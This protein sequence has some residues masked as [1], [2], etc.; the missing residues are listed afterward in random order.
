MINS[1]RMFLSSLQSGLSSY[2]Q[3]KHSQTNYSK[4][5]DLNWLQQMSFAVWLSLSLITSYFNLFSFIIL[6]PRKPGN[7][8]SLHR[9]T[10][11]KQSEIRSSLRLVCISWSQFRL[12]IMILPRNSSTLPGDLCF[13]SKDYSSSSVYLVACP[14]SIRCILYCA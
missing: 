10:I 7:L 13:K 8:P 9:V 3:L 6:V 12:A 1:R 14:K 2:E 4:S 5:E 11:M